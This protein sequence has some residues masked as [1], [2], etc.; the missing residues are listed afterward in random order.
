[1]VEIKSRISQKLTLGWSLSAN[2][3][4]MAFCL[5]FTTDHKKNVLHTETEMKL[6]SILIVSLHQKK[7][8]D[9][10]HNKY[11]GSTKMCFHDYER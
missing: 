8:K 9:R 11:A 10:Y 6:Q 1:M 2:L 4:S 7:D 3:V 5:A